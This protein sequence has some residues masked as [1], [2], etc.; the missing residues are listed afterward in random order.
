MGVR[1]G[2]VILTAAVALACPK[3]GVLTGRCSLDFCLD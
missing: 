1:G 3:F 2:I